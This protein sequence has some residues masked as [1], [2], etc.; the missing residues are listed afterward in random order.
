MIFSFSEV[1]YVITFLHNLNEVNVK[2]GFRE[3]KC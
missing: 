1:M 2:D 3:D